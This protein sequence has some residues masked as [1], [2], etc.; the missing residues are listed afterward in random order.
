[1]KFKVGDKVKDIEWEDDPVF[2]VVE[3]VSSDGTVTVA[4]RYRGNLTYGLN[5][6]P[7]NDII[8]LTPLEELL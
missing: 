2:G 5:N 1:M 7:L 3:E 6:Y 8:L 4:Y